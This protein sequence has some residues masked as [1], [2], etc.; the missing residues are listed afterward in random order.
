[1]ETANQHAKNKAVLIAAV[2]FVVSVCLFA[3]LR[4]GKIFAVDGAA[5]CVEVFRR[6]T[7]FFHPNNHMLYPVDVL[8]WNRLL[9]GLGIR[10]SSAEQFFTHTQL[11]NCFAGAACLA[12]L[13]YLVNLVSSSMRPALGIVLAYG[14]SK[15]FLLHATNS[16]EP[17]VGVFWSFLAICFAVLSLKRKSN[18]PIVISALFFSL[19]MA[20]YQ[21]TIFLAPA[22]IVLI[23]KGRSDRDG[24]RLFSPARFVE[25]CEFVV[26]GIASCAAIFGWAYWREGYRGAA[27]FKNFFAHGD[28]RVYLGVGIGKLLTVPIGLVRNIFPVLPHFNGIRGLLAGPKLSLIWLLLVFGA[29]CAFLIVYARR[30]LARWSGLAVELRLG[31]LA[32]TVGFAFTIIPLII[33]DPSYDKLWLQPLACLAFVVGSGLEPISTDRRFCLWMARVFPALVLVGVSMN[34]TWVVPDHDIKSPDLEE[35]QRL[36]DS[37]GQR[38]LLIGDWDDISTLYGYGWAH[39]GQFMSFPSEAVVF[40]PDSVAH[41]REAVEEA[42][43]RGGRVYFLSILD[44]PKKTWNSFLGSRC[45]VPYSTIDFYR[46]HSK[47]R[48]LYYAQNSPVVLRQFDPSYP[49]RRSQ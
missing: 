27:L 11:M 46:A 44:V 33:W 9:G 18:W 22:A 24:S 40:G 8:V 7:I 39:D 13:F 41:L 1:M 49:V 26:A 28:A 47:L 36:A 42:Q 30:L 2:I 10:A 15:A 45:G 35:A 43:K 38:D 5:R 37:L 25:F 19:A 29:L 4:S 3:L 34:F 20:T 23:W 14:L 31:I 17:M 16:A 32:S 6:Q 12:I 48:A 21:S